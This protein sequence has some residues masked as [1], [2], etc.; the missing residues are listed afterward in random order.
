MNVVLL[1]RKRKKKKRKKPQEDEFNDI[2]FAILNIY[3]SC[4]QRMIR[5]IS[6]V[7]KS[8]IICKHS[9]Q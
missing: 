7:G 5:E 3:I 6:W 4:G 8:H 9:Q 2:L 1:P